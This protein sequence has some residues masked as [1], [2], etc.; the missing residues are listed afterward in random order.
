M[1]DLLSEVHPEL[2]AEWLDISELP[3]NMLV[4]VGTVRM[5][6]CVVFEMMGL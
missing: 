1:G 4:C 6:D 3:F 5:T 2:I